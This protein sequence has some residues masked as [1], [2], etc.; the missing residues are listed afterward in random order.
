MHDTYRILELLGA[1]TSTFIAFNQTQVRAL[2][3]MKEQQLRRA[4]MESREIGV[5]KPWYP[6]SS[7]V[8]EHDE[9]A[10]LGYLDE[11]LEEK[12]IT[13]AGDDLIWAN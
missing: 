6:P 3:D 9:R 11:V 7:Q 1:A 5:E 12:A 10:R 4:D 2:K 13:G 8:S